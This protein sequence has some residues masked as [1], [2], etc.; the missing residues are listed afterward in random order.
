MR[1]RTGVIE[2]EVGSTLHLGAGAVCRRVLA[3]VDQEQIN[4]KKTLQ[5]CVPVSVLVLALAGCADDASIDDSEMP[6]GSTEQ[7]MVGPNP[8]LDA[9]VIGGAV[10]GYYRDLAVTP[11]GI[12]LTRSSDGVVDLR[13]FNGAYV[14]SFGRNYANIDY[15]TDLGTV[16]SSNTNSRVYVGISSGGSTASFAYPAGVTSVSDVAAVKLSGDNYAI[17]IAYS[18]GYGPAMAHRKGTYNRVT[19]SLT[20]DASPTCSLAYRSAL[21]AKDNQMMTFLSYTLLRF[22][23]VNLQ[24]CSITQEKFVAP[25]QEHAYAVITEEDWD[26]VNPLGFD[27]FNGK[28]YILDRYRGYDGHMSQSIVTIPNNQIVF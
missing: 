28:Y 27:Y 19:K 8:E 22:E 13:S 20:W 15:H 7:A 6:N 18:A 5:L 16:A 10:D 1:G 9:T 17:W 3:E 2:P 11:G 26:T 12:F 23:K 14:G 21:A 4:M 25:Y 24:T